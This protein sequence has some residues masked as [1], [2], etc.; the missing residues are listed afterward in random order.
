M[1]FRLHLIKALKWLVIA[2]L[3][4]AMAYAAFRGYL[5]PEFLIGFANGVLC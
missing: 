2:V 5:S 1:L 4:A 3:A